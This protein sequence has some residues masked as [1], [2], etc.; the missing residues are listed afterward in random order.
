MPISFISVLGQDNNVNECNTHSLYCTVGYYVRQY[1][2]QICLLNRLYTGRKQILLFLK[3]I[4]KLH[5]CIYHVQVR[6]DNTTMN[7]LNHDA[8]TCLRASNLWN[9]FMQ[10]F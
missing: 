2:Q 3:R 5:N 10:K 7:L 4:R 8:C 1:N 9:I 6:Q